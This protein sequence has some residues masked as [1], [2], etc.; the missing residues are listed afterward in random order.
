GFDEQYGARPLRRAIQKYV[1]DDL[2]DEILKGNLK[3]GAKVVADLDKKKNKLK[4]KFLSGLLTKKEEP[5]LLLDNYD[6]TDLQS[7]TPAGDIEG[8]ADFGS[9]TNKN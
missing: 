6:K 4:F 1:E 7:E 5:N 8:N 3:N 2:A 9:E